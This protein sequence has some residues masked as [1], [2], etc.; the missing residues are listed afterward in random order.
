MTSTFT[1]RQDGTFA[2]KP[3]TPRKTPGR[4][5]NGQQTLRAK[6]ILREMANRSIDWWVMSEDL[7]DL[8]SR[9]ILGTGGRIEVIFRPNN[10]AAHERLIKAATRMLK[11]AGYPIV[12][13]ERMGIE[14]NS[15]QCVRSRLAR[16]LPFAA[17]TMCQTSSSLTRHFPSSAAVNPAL[18]SLRRLFASLTTSWD[19]NRRDRKAKHR[20]N[21]AR[22]SCDRT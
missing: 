19:P 8:E 21:S 10:L 13:V 1:A 14:T 11:V 5:A 9:V 4:N 6:V 3:S 22:H 7:P 16:I 17:V 12:P 18:T 2:R 20:M 15:H